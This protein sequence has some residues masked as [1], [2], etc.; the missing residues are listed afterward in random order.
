MGSSRS[1]VLVTGAGGFIGGRLVEVLMQS[2]RF[3]PVPA[4][5]RWA[6]SARIGRHPVDPVMCDLLDS[7]QIRAALSGIDFV[8]HCAVGDAASTIDGTRNL[9]REAQLAG[10]RRV[11]H[12]ST[13]DVYGPAE[14]AV[15]E[16]AAL[17]RTGRPYGDSKIEAEEACREFSEAGLGVVILR[18][19]IVYGPFSD[20]WVS[21]YAGRFSQGSWLLSRDTCQGLCNLLYVDDLV[22]A[23]LL[24]LEAEGVD[25]QA[26]NVNGPE[27]VTWQDYFDG[28]NQALGYPPLPR[29]GTLRSRVS[30]LAAAPVKKLAKVT[31]SRFQEPVMRVYRSSRR[32]R[33]LMKGV[34]GIL[35]RAPS[36]AEFDL[37]SRGA[38]YPIDKAAQALG[39]TPSVSVPEGVRLS[40]AWALHEGIASPRED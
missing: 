1:K 13:I 4:V 17:V 38:T 18:P 6:S 11:V 35:R 23:C 2:Q 33:T 32:A 5:R 7:D 30:S 24:A 39:F 14:G 26:F 31:V 16:D 36:P 9:L 19:T 27:V 28:L 15:S 25:G 3:R 22:Q 37:Y 8:V 10:V 29:P 34:E 20:T 40:A 21:G 12:L